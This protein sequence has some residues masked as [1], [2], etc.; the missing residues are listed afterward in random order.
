DN[1]NIIAEM[2]PGPSRLFYWGDALSAEVVIDENG[3]SLMITN[4]A[5]DPDDI[6][7]AQF[8]YDHLYEIGKTY[9]FTFEVMGD[10]GVVTSYFQNY[11]SYTTCGVCDAFE[12]N[13]E[14]KNITIKGTVEDTGE[15]VNRWVANI[16]D[17][18]GTFYIRNMKIYTLGKNPFEVGEEFEYNKVRYAVIDPSALTCEVIATNSISTDINI[19]DVAIYNMTNLTVVEIGNKSFTNSSNLLSVSIP[20]TIEKIG[21]DAF[22]GCDRLTS[23]RWRGNRKMPA[24]VAESIGNPNL[25]VYVD[26]AKF[27]PEGLDH[28]VVADGVCEKLVLTPGYP[29]TPVSEFTAKTSSMTK[30]FKQ[31]TGIGG[32][33]GWETIV[34]PFDAVKVTSPEGHTLLPYSSVTDVRRQ[35]PYWLY[36]ADPAGEWQAAEG[37]KAG[38][39]YLVSMPNNPRYNPAYNISGPVTFSNPKSQRIAP[40]TT[41][42]YAVTWASGREFRSLWL[43]LD[44]AQ[45]AIAMGLNVNIDNLTDDNGEVLAPGSAFHVGIMP[46]PLEAYVTRTDA[47]RAFRIS[48]LQSAVSYMPEAD[49]LNISCDGRTLLLKSNKD[50]SVE[51]Y[52]ADGTL[53]RRVDLKAGES[54]YV[55]SL[56][57]GVCIIAGRKIMIR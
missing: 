32:C 37:I 49:G 53:L 8:A 18:E 36:E 48:G 45:A 2:Y 46:I 34:L 42:P 23:L 28:N 4:S 15:I 27:A 12:I 41:A 22:T 33:S 30:E 10:Y 50:C 7:S 38:V 26:S 56:P 29:F 19:P 57:Q 14:W 39:P 16:G 52:S 31:V 44:E 3:E 9:Y 25:L 55:D 1:D 35:R 24:G 51:V 40:E 43:P 54:V 47:S 17:Y 21:I 20:S 6:W 5:P 13:S 11:N